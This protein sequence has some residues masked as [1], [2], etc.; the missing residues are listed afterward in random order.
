MEH[1]PLRFPV[2]SFSMQQFDSFSCVY[3]CRLHRM[4]LKTCSMF[5]PVLGSRHNTVVTKMIKTKVKS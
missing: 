5:K 4:F 2:E 3:L 1:L